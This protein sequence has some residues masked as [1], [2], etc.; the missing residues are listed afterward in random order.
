MRRHISVLMMYI[1]SSIY[2]V[3]LLLAL[4]VS[5]QFLLFWQ[6]MKGYST[7]FPLG[8]EKIFDR[9]LLPWT[10]G[11]MSLVWYWVKYRL[12]KPFKPNDNLQ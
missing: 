4:M 11:I 10:F 8:L 12:E 7:K 9:T 3:I 1:R 6:S 5:A 2:Q